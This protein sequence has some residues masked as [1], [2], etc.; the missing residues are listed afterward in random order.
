MIS[1]FIRRHLT[2][3]IKRGHG[4]RRGE[5]WITKL[6]KELELQNSF[7]STMNDNGDSNK[8]KEKPAWELILR[9]GIF[10]VGIFRGGQVGTHQGE[11]DGWEF[12]WYLEELDIQE[13]LKLILQKYFQKTILI[14]QVLFKD[15]LTQIWKSPYMFVFI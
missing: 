1:K 3:L 5:G 2:E 8:K 7:L 13:K 10:W 15:T 11:F 6:Q 14:A 9:V 12:S 4:G